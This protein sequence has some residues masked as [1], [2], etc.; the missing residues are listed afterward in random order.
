MIKLIEFIIRTIVL[1]T[2]TP[3]LSICCSL[4]GLIFWNYKFMELGDQIIQLIL[5]GE[6]IE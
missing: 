5:Y 4:C 6:T 2:L 3:I 1:I